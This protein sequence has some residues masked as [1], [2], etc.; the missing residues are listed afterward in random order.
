MAKKPCSRRESPPTPAHPGTTKTGLS[1]R[2]SRVRVPSLPLKSLQ[3]GILCCHDGRQGR[4]DYTNV[5]SRRAQTA[6]KGAET[7]S[8]VTIS[9]RFRPHRNRPRARRA[10]TQNGRRSRPATPVAKGVQGD[11]CAYAAGDAAAARTASERSVGGPAPSHRHRGADRGRL[12]PTMIEGGKPTA[13]DVA[14][15]CAWAEF[16][17]CP[18]GNPTGAQTSKLAPRVAGE[19]QA[20]LAP[21]AR[22]HRQRRRVSL[23]ATSAPPS[24]S[25][26]SAT[27]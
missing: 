21:G 24:T 26:A 1:R 7:P 12:S 17:S 22:A 20:R 10:T 18:Q 15:S 2:R 14:S 9:S 23:P 11:S 13:I 25:S 8:R 27:P 4:G 16:V 5:C 19:L 3:I 6:Q